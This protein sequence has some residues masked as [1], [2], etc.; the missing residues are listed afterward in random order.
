MINEPG[1][2]SRVQIQAP[3]WVFFYTTDINGIQGSLAF[4]SVRRRNHSQKK[5][6]Q[7]IFQTDYGKADEAKTSSVRFCEY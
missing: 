1:P 6:V 3:R 2:V 5:H 4:T 7:G